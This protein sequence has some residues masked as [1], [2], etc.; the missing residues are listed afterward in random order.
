MLTPDV[1]IEIPVADLERRFR[2]MLETQGFSFEKEFSQCRSLADV[3]DYPFDKLPIYP[4]LK[5]LIRQTTVHEVRVLEDYLR[6]IVFNHTDHNPIQRVDFELILYFNSKLM[7]YLSRRF[8]SDFELMMKNFH[9]RLAPAFWF[10]KHIP[11]WIKLE[12]H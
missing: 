6:Y 1:I 11:F 10:D 3:L 8:K 2:F 12:Y 5:T 9:A 7:T 4:R